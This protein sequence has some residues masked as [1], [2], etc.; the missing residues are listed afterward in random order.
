MHQRAKVID[1]LSK[2][3]QGKDKATANNNVHYSKES[4]GIQKKHPLAGIDKSKLDEV[5]LSDELIQ[6]VTKLLTDLNVMEGST[7]SKSMAEEGQDN[8]IKRIN[9]SVHSKKNFGL[10]W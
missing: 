7:E 10:W 1:K 4:T 2:R 3:V 5:K 9:T 8:V 6:I